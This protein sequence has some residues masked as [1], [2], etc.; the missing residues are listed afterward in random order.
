MSESDRRD[1]EGLFPVYL[2]FGG[3]LAPYEWQQQ[4]ALGKKTHGRLDPEFIYLLVLSE[5]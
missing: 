2:F 3:C 1:R 4:K 5:G